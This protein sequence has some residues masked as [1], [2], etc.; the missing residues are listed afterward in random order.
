MTSG[1]KTSAPAKALALALLAAALALADSL[2]RFPLL[3][4]ALQTVCAALIVFV[5]LRGARLREEIAVPPADPWLGSLLGAAAA[6]LSVLGWFG[7]SPAF[8]HDW[9][10]PL[11]ALQAHDQLA[12]LASIWLP[13]GSGAPAVQALGNYP[14]A[15]FTWASAFVLPTNLALV[16]LFAL[17]GACAGAGIAVLAS[18][19]GLPRAY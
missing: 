11:D 10:W 18:Q 6:A 16:V 1:L 8:A 13:W 2:A 17:L 3:T 14:I 4:T 19:T 12:S 7:A 9:K 15:I 5:L